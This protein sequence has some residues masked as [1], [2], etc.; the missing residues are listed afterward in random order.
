MIFD[1]FD[2]FWEKCKKFRCIFLAISWIAEHFVLASIL[3]RN[4]KQELYVQALV[5]SS[6]MLAM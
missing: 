4:A 5:K 3:Y 6:F 1:I 2:F